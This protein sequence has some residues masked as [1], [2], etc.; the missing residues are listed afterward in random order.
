MK[1]IKGEMEKYLDADTDLIVILTKIEYH[2]EIT[3]FCEKVIKELN[4]R[5]YQIRAY[6]DYRKWTGPQ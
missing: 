1:T 5:T 4:S 3:N 2:K 6:I